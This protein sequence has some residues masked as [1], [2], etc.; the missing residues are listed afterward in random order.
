MSLESRHLWC[1]AIMIHIVAQIFTLHTYV[2]IYTHILFGGTDR[3]FLASERHVRLILNDFYS[4]RGSKLPVEAAEQL[5]V[6]F[7]NQSHTE[8]AISSQCVWLQP[9]KLSEAPKRKKKN[10]TVTHLTYCDRSV[11][12]SARSPSC[13][14]RCSQTVSLLFH[15]HKICIWPLPSTHPTLLSHIYALVNIT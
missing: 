5:Q 12:S 15:V 6:F 2:C 10:W 7:I 4:L 11:T 13:C 9:Q 14:Q 8:T 1:R 3:L